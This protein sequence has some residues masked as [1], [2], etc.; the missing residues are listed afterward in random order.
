[1]EERDPTCSVPGCDIQYPLER[2][3]WRTDFAKGGE[4]KLDN[5]LRVCG[6]HHHLKTHKGW[7]FEGSPGNFRFVGPDDR[8]GG[9]RSGADPPDPDPPGP[10]RTGA[11]PPAQ[12]KFL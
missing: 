1:L 11:D 10:D 6:H 4:T 3:H 8:S 5:L 9:D 12:G 7:R 2:D